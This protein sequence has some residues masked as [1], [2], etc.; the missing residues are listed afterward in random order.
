MHH[1]PNP[2]QNSIPRK[3][4]NLLFIG[5]H[6]RVH[7]GV[8]GGDVQLCSRQSMSPPMRYADNSWHDR[9][10]DLDRYFYRASTRG[11]RDAL[12]IAY[13]KASSI[14]RMYVE[15]AAFFAFRKHM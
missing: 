2:V 14:L 3:W 11:D 9:V 7:S 4:I 5:Q 15:G 1:H 8:F 12:P 10:G 6:I 13:L